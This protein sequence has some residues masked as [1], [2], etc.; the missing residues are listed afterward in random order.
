M[1][2]IL[3]LQKVTISFCLLCFH[4]YKE[5]S[6][7]I[8]FPFKWTFLFDTQRSLFN[9]KSPYSAA[10]TSIVT[11]LFKG[12]PILLHIIK[13]NKFIS[14]ARP[15][16][17]ICIAMQILLHIFPHSIAWVDFFYLFRNE[18][19]WSLTMTIPYFRIVAIKFD[20][21][22]FDLSFFHLW[23]HGN[24]TCDK[25]KCSLYGLILI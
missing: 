6:C 9:S 16:N 1:L 10:Y 4:F 21:I 25:S 14:Y 24:C 13:H 5:N 17:G 20:L 3:Q 12:K 19:L 7:C 22:M 15:K 23:C 2:N 8:T 11:D 18:K